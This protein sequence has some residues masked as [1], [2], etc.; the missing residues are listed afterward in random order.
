MLEVAVNLTTLILS[1]NLLSC[2]AATLEDQQENM[3]GSG[4]DFGAPLQNLITL[5]CAGDFEEPVAAALK[6]VGNRIASTTSWDIINA[7]DDNPEAIRQKAAIFLALVKF[8]S[9]SREAIRNASKSWLLVV[10]IP[11]LDD[12]LGQLPSYISL[13]VEGVRLQLV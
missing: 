7:I 1:S 8:G 3:I 6:A 9:V 4:S 12:L 11:M 2:D 13:P 5:N 10:A